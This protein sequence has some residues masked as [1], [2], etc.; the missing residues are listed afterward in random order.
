MEQWACTTVLIVIA[1]QASS[2][3]T[4]DRQQFDQFWLFVLEWKMAVSASENREMI[5]R[6]PVWTAWSDLSGVI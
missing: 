4:A 2:A 1:M 3:D 5:T 6:V